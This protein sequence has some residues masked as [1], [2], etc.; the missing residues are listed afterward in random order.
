MADRGMF[1]TS[2]LVP[3]LAER[4]VHLSREQAAS[5]WTSTSSPGTRSSAS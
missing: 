3:L 4:G 1:A 5:G 2:A